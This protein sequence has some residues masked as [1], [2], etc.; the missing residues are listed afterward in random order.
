VTDVCSA[1]DIIAKNRKDYLLY[2]CLHLL[3]MGSLMNGAIANAASYKLLLMS[4]PRINPLFQ[5]Q[6]IK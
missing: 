3:N 2:E 6:H 1:L 5:S 4:P